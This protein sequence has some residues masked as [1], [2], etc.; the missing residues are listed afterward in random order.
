MSDSFRREVE[1]ESQSFIRDSRERVRLSVG[2]IE[3]ALERCNEMQ[4]GS[5]VKREARLRLL[6]KD[7]AKLDMIQDLADS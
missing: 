7:P 3:D 6:A 4:L 5:S 2:K 1:Q